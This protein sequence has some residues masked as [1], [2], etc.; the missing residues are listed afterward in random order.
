[1]AV[2]RIVPAILTDDPLALRDMVRR[3]EGFASWVQ[4]DIMD[5]LFVPSRSIGSQDIVGTTPGF[6][7]EA[8]LMVRA[9][10]G[11]I[12]EFA[13]AGAKRIIF[14]YEAAEHPHAIAESVRSVGVGAGL[15]L[16]PDTPVSVISP[17]LASKLDCVLFLSVYP[18]FYGQPFIPEVLD[19]VRNLHQRFPGLVLGID[20][21]IKEGN[22]AEVAQAGADEICVGSAIFGQDDPAEAYKRLVEL[23]EVGW[24][25]LDDRPVTV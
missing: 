7:W 24:R 4:F 19:K 14:H 15:A 18:G 13:R 10:G 12:K 8:H 25:R 22:I 9:P 17:A 2:R 16:S 3:A 6:P 1:M 11:Y 20:G 5:G 23:A 21:G